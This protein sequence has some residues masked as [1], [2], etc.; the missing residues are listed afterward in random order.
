MDIVVPAGG[1]LGDL[2]ARALG[3]KK[4]AGTSNQPIVIIPANRN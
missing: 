3:V 2:L 1:Q 4:T